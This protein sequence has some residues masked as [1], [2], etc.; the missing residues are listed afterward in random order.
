MRIEVIK[1]LPG[2]IALS[3]C[4]ANAGMSLESYSITGTKQA[5]RSGKGLVEVSLRSRQGL[6]EVSSG[7]R[8]G[9]VRVS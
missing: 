3:L 4:I 8:G 6:V 2:F 1:G 9:L 5:V 7:S